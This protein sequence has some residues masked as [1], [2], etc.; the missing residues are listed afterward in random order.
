MAEAM[1]FK[2]NSIYT[3]E[4]ADYKDVS[5]YESDRIRRLPGVASKRFEI[6]F[7]SSFFFL[8]FFFV[9]FRFII[10]F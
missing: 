4:K 8:V 7:G 6:R 2:M 1:L 10:L 3:P 5:F 9:F